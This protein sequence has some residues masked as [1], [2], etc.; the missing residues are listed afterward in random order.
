[1]ALALVCGSAAAS[2]LDSAT[3][4][5][6]PVEFKEVKNINDSGVQ[7]Q[8]DGREYTVRGHLTGPR[9]A[10][11]GAQSPEV[12]LYLTGFEEAE[13]IWRFKALPGHDFAAAMAAEGHVSLTIDMLGYGA[14]AHPNGSQLCMGSQAALTHQLIQRLRAGRYRVDKAGVTPVSFA[15]VVLAGQDIGGAVAEVE[16][17]SY[18]DVDALV[19]DFW[20]DGELTAEPF[21]LLAKLNEV[22]AKG[23]EE[24]NGY[25]HFAPQEESYWRE[26]L[27]AEG[28]E[29]SLIEA[30]FR[31][32]EK[33]PCGYGTSLPPTVTTDRVRDGEI[34]VP[35]LIMF[36][37][38][39]PLIWTR[40]GEEEQQN[41]FTGTSDKE[42]V[43][44]PEAAHF[45]M[46]ERTLPMAHIVSSWLCKR[47]LVAIPCK[48]S[49]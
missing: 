36:G 39:K 46:L 2:P 35:V 18:K 22:C 33:N 30:T 1:L 4:Y 29:P 37:N 6:L 43:F 40:K 38:E 19:T 25:A 5:V 15:K 48:A 34:H 14:S 11:E 17:Y 26:N 7:C 27:F 16:A 47:N 10:L 24:G 21:K 20:S 42:T 13:W 23:G 9:A 12:T 28:A 49:G 32:R 45:A 31:M 44:I 3:A 41:N 8:S